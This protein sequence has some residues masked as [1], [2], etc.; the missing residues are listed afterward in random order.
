MAYQ[1]YHVAVIIPAHNEESSIGRIVRG[2]KA[3]RDPWSLDAMI[4]DI[5]VCDNASTDATAHNAKQEGGH[6]C[7]EAAMG[8][9]AACLKGMS[10]LG[11]EGQQMPDLVVFLDG[12]YSVNLSEI[13]SLLDELL[14]GHD[15]VVGR[16][17]ARLQE[18]GAM[19]WHQRFGTFLAS[20]L[21]QQIWQQP[22]GDLGPFRAMK[23]SSL[24]QLNMQDR[25]F[26]WTVEMQVK[27]LQAGMQYIEVPVSTRCRMG[28]SKISGTVRGT[29]GAAKGIF[30]KI[31]ELR[32]QEADFLASFKRVHAVQKSKILV[33][34][35]RLFPK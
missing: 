1:D 20:R 17:E 7:Y 35:R 10:Q 33:D 27:A 26:G 34:E 14:D 15:L 28:V 12:D 6:V 8:Y 2:L 25:T 11:R 3:L 22:V 31:F 30:G 24:M 21:I 16:R 19:G 29:I 4:D 23:F 9:G 5:I 18:R 32:R 13:P